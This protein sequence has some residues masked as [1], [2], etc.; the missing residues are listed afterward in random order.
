MTGITTW[1]EANPVLFG[2]GFAVGVSIFLLVVFAVSFRWAGQSMRPLVFFFGFLGIVGGPQAA[3]HLFSA[4]FREETESAPA[5]TSAY[6]ADL[7]KFE[8]RDG[9]FVDRE[10][11][12]GGDYDRDLVREAK[13]GFV[14]VM[15]AADHV[16]IAFYPTGEMV[17]ASLLPDE[18]SAQAA[19]DGL[20]RMFVF[21]DATGDDARGWAA[22]RGTAGDR[23]F[24]LRAGRV[25]MLWTGPDD[26]AVTKRRDA[27]SVVS[28]IEQPAPNELITEAQ[29][30]GFASKIRAFFKNPVVFAVAIALNLIA[31][32]GWFFWGSAWATRKLPAPGAMPV[33][34]AEL[35]SR[36]LEINPIDTP[37]EVN[38]ITEGE[39]I[40]ISWKYGDAR[41]ISLASA[42]GRR[43]SHKLVLHLD[44]R[45]RKVNV[46]E[47]WASFDWS[48][49]G[50]GANIHWKKQ[51][52]MVFFEYQ[53]ERVFGIQIGP[54]GRPTGD[55]SYTYTF[56]LQELKQPIISVVTT[57]GWT[58]QPLMVHFG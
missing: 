10:A 24:L 43:R 6:E 14:G 42:H 49:G 4:I 17:V 30:A 41:W 36:L 52:G 35:Q 48:A 56:N 20:G 33:S 44:E 32:V 40:S 25:V 38:V 12:F 29:P 15:D 23:A 50:G 22:T 57:A 1:I 19:H 53:H 11:I 16:E 28:E 21:Q 31:G 2:L 3:V 45:R 27:C 26:A 54:D 18:A 7:A 39:K 37:V 51:M 55:L 5:L 13:A 9:Q 58:W 47:Y 34:A 8:V 46:L